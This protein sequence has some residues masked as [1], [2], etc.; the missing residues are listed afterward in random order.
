MPGYRSV[1]DALS[2]VAADLAREASS[3]EADGDR[4]AAVRLYEQAIA[5][6]RAERPEMPGFVCGRLAA[7]Y[8]RMGRYEDE[9][10][11]L[12]AYRDSQTDEVAHARFDARLSK[13]RAIAEKFTRPD[14]GALASIR[15][16]RR[17]SE[18]RAARRTRLLG[19]RQGEAPPATTDAAPVD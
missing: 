9:V 8:R 10:A 13:A 5:V 19:E 14:S 4:D 15:A 1:P 7:A 11:L 17:N 2:G 12:E 3:L 6:A 18:T 16:I